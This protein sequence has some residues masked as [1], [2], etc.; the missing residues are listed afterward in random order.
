MKKRSKVLL[1]FE[2]KTFK[3]IR[4]NDSSDI[5]RCIL[6]FRRG[7]VII[8][9]GSRRNFFFYFYLFLHRYIDSI[10]DLSISSWVI[11]QSFVHIHTNMV[12]A[13]VN[14]VYVQ[15]VMVS[16]ERY[17]TIF[18]SYIIKIAFYLVWVD[19]LSSMLSR[20]FQ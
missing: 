4:I 3:P 2:R 18:P 12:R 17:I 1:Y 8:E 5:F 16:S 20:I 6:H 7:F 13:V 19:D 15:M 14:A 10:V 11:H 9:S